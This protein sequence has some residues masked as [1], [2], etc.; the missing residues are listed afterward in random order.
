MIMIND[1][2]N[3]NKKMW[4]YVK[5][6]PYTHIMNCTIINMNKKE[7]SCETFLHQVRNIFEIKNDT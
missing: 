1:K 3:K 6:H 7:Y 2:K 5:W 4:P